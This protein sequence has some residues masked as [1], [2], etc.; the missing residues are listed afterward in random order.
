MLAIGFTGHSGAWT[1]VLRDETGT[2]VAE[3]GHKHP[4]RDSTSTYKSAA[5]PCMKQIVRAAR[6]PAYREFC[7]KPITDRADELADVIGLGPVQCYGQ[8]FTP[9]LG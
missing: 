6:L 8:Q 9:A 5:I 4:N 7:A 2:V 1:G 3:C